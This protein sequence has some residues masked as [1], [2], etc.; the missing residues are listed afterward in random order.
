MPRH[1]HTLRQIQ[2]QLDRIERAVTMPLITVASEV[3]D[4]PLYP[5]HDGRRRGLPSYEPD[6]RITYP[7][8]G[9]SRPL[10]DGELAALRRRF[11]DIVTPFMP[12]PRAVLRRPLGARDVEDDDEGDG[13]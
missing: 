9:E 10:Y 12:N 1:S 13:E 6:W 7:G 5:G 11:P 2:A 8:R 3:V 4:T